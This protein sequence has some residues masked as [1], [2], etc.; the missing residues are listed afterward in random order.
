M[1]FKW[2]DW[3][4]DE[5]A[6]DKLLRDASVITKEYEIWNYPLE[7]VEAKIDGDWHSTYTSPLW[8][9]YDTVKRYRNF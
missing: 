9:Y 6:L 1:K 3:R 4:G 5:E 8:E 2:V 7:S